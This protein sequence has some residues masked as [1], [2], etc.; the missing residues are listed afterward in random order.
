[1]HEVRRS[2]GQPLDPATRAFMEPRFG[3]DFSRVRVHADDQAGGS[4]RAVNAQAYAVGN[5]EKQRATLNATNRS[6][7]VPAI[8]TPQ[9]QPSRERASDDPDTPMYS[10]DGVRVSRQSGTCR[11]GGGSSVCNMNTGNYDITANGNTCCTKDCTQQHEQT[12]VAD[13]TASGC[14]KAASAAYT[15]KG[16]DK[17]VVVGKYNDWMAVADPVTECHAYNAGVAC[18]EALE[19]TKDCAGAGKGT[20]CCKDIAGYKSFYGNLAKTTCATA[21]A[22]MPACPAF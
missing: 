15:A 21:P 2:T 7:S 11:N 5:V 22:K 17:N 3:H 16:A 9:V 1:V 18:A 14:C 4:P 6:G 13:V 8:S 20:D 19:K 10:P 12:H